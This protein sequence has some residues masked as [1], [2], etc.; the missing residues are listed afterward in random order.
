MSSKY[1]FNISGSIVT[2]VYE[3]DNGKFK[4]EKIEEDESWVYDASTSSVTLVEE[5]GDK[6]KQKKIFTDLDGDGIYE[7]S[8][9]IT[10]NDGAGNAS[11]NSSTSSDQE[12]YKLTIQNGVVVSVYEYEHGDWE[13][14][15]LDE[16]EVWTLNQDGTI[17]RTEDGDDEIK[18]YSPT[19]VGEETLYSLTSKIDSEGNISAQYDEDDRDGD[20]T[21][22]DLLYGS[23]TDDH[24]S[25]GLGDDDIE[26][27][28]GDDFVD[29]G[30]GSDVLIGGAGDDDLNGGVGDDVIFGGAD[31]DDLDG[32]DGVDTADYTDVTTALD[33]D[34]QTGTVTGAGSDTLTSIENATGG[35]GD[36]SIDGNAAAND[37]LGGSGSDVISG[38]GGNDLLYAGDGDDTVYG[39]LG[40][41]LIIG[42]DGKGN[43]KY[44]GGTGTDT[45]KYTS[46]TA[47]ITVDL[48]KGTATSK[49]GKDAA[50][51]GTDSLNGIE[52]VIAG[53]YDDIVKGSTGANMLT[54]GLGSDSLYGG[55][56]KL[57]DIF[58]FNAISESKVGSTRDKV[59]NLVSGVDNIDLKTIDAN[60]NA[61]GDQAFKSLSTKASANSLWYAVKD[62]DGN[63][64]TKDIVV[65]GDVNGDT[66]ADFEIG[67]VGVTSIAATDFV[68]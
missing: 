13:Q 51:I 39:G 16:G 4:S 11:L 12:A 40:D 46:A 26:T 1:K 8:G 32:G 58:D 19:T 28:D 20:G 67:L 9:H 42:G 61:S 2:A 21:D 34:L 35:T 48:A 66:K 47:A 45:V 33:I 5:S 68:L 60:T 44:I 53:N 38:E 15:D 37:L 63:T 64:L 57:K 30:D 24:L 54:G 22:D 27:G 25:G 3:Y 49:A 55:A 65:Y 62:V 14:K 18:I 50:N 59:Y 10:G 52:N 29:G 31:N 23:K 6:F 41:D 56:D 43:D 7:K 36:D 17:S